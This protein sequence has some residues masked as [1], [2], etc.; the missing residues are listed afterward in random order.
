VLTLA[1]GLCA[2][3]PVIAAAVRALHEGWQPV[4]DRGIIATRSYD[5]LSSHMPLVGQYSFAG[6][7]TGKLTYSFGPMLYWLLAPAAHYGA[8]A[9]FVVTMAAVNAGSVVCAVALARRR[10]GLLLAALAALA[11][12]LMCRSLAANNFYDIWNPSA[13]L[14]PLLALVFVCW[15]LACG[16]FRLLPLA[17]LLGSFELQCEDAFVP[18]A[19]AA[20]VIGLA[21]AALWYR[22]RRDQPAGP[23]AAS[24][25]FGDSRRARAWVAAALVVAVLCWTPALIDQPSGMGNIGHVLAAA[26]ERRAPL[27]ATVGLRAVAR[28]VGVAPWWLTRPS[29]PFVRKF[30]VRRTA[31]TTVSISAAL[32]LA[33]LLLAVA[34]A[35]RRGRADLVAG[36]TLALALCGAVFS[37]ADAT[38]STPQFL[39][40]TLGYT[41]WSA[42]VIGMFTWL[43][44]LW[45]LLVLS[46]LAPRLGRAGEALRERIGSSRAAGRPRSLALAAFAALALAAAGG[47]A[48]AAAGEPDEHAF[49]FAALRELNARLGAVPR[50]HTVFLSAKL[51]G[52]ITPLRP[53]LTYEL[54]R[55]G[56]RALGVGAYLRTGHWY[57]RSEHPYDYIVWV[58]DNR[59]PPVRGARV[60]AVAHVPKNG[61][62]HTVEVAISPARPLKSKPRRRA[63]RGSRA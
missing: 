36:A 54:R 8:P 62:E 48:G 49:E 21:G 26:G 30:D 35:L 20:L 37:V 7:V 39:A 34:L 45:A 29:N 10:G 27:G 44:A 32:I 33:W 17:A 42:T 5:V 2:A 6:S 18:P 60:I 57:E 9:S 50:G 55:R 52:L 59:R 1:L 15:S 11:I 14:F 56:V 40:A 58:Y 38:P 43:M 12:G 4:A 47:A 13:G 22:R 61:R 23:P 16:E 24:G 3:L 28:T 46:G 53:E 41:L 63:A 31:P 51:D 19:L 25:S